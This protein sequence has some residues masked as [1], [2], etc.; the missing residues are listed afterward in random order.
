MRMRTTAILA[1]AFAAAVWATPAQAKMV[2]V[3]NP[4]GVEPVPSGAGTC[5][6]LEWA[7]EHRGAVKQ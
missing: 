1:A 3:K 6:A 4:G 5:L 7:S 2:Y